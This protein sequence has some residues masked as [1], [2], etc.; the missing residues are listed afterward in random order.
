MSDSDSAEEYDTFNTNDASDGGGGGGTSF[1]FDPASIAHVTATVEASAA[2]SQRRHHR[3]SSAASRGTRSAATTQLATDVG[4][5]VVRSRIPFLKSVTFFDPEIYYRKDEAAAEEGN[6]TTD[7]VDDENNNTDVDDDDVD[8]DDDD[9]TVEINNIQHWD[10]HLQDPPSENEDNQTK[11][12]LRQKISQSKLGTVLKLNK[13]PRLIIQDYEGLLEYSSIQSGD[14]LL[15]INKHVIDPRTTTAQDARRFMNECVEEEGV[16]NIVT[17]NP[18]GEDV[19]INVTVI[20][21]RRD[22]NYNELGLV[23]W[24]W[25]YLCVRQI[26]EGS[27]F[28]HTPIQEMDQIAAINDID[29]SKMRT[30]AFAQCV[31]ELPVELTITLIRRK[32]RYTGSFK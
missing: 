29:C 12:S 3:F 17:E 9:V 11:K 8:D 31:L 21:P 15:S 28:E 10:V 19:L 14:S 7:N 32:H 2:P 13:T 20:K 26:N 5:T 18:H 24:N 23:V 6:D 25:P 16:L 1:L 30:K 22:M 27:I 4:S